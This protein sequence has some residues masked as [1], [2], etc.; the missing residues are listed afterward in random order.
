MFAEH[1]KIVSLVMAV[2][3]LCIK[4]EALGKIPIARY[5]EEVGKCRRDMTFLVF[6][7]VWGW[8]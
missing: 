4:V 3:A 5:K 8:L 6:S 1:T 2:L 7:W